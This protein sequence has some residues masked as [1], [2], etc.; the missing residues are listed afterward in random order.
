MVDGRWSGLMYVSRL[1]TL[2][3]FLICGKGG[4]MWWVVVS[5]ALN[6]SKLLLPIRT[7]KDTKQYKQP[8]RGAVAS[9]AASS[10]TPPHLYH[11]PPPK[12][13]T[14]A[15]HAPPPPPPPNPTVSPPTWPFS[16]PIPLSHPNSPTDRW[17]SLRTRPRYLRSWSCW[18]ENVL[19]CIERRRGTWKCWGKRW[20][21]VMRFWRGCRR[22]FWWAFVLDVFSCLLWLMHL[23]SYN[24]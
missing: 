24:S 23:M 2:E 20:G 4:K 1:S 14:Q 22:C 16:S 5:I 18:N 13:W 6:V 11:A 15:T 9:E 7:N 21:F 10:R 8:W 3:I 17:T 12:Q 19:R